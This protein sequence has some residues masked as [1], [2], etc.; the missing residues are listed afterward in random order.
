M[1][2][3]CASFVEDKDEYVAKNENAEAHNMR[4]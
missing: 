3:S 1:M 4:T 2:L